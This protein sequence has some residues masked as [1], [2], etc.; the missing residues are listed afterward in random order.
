MM[1][2]RSG[3]VRN[4][5]TLLSGAA[6]AQLVN[7]GAFILIGRIYTPE[8]FGIF[9]ILTVSI[10]VLSVIVNGRYEL[11]ILLPKD[12][13]TAQSLFW[14]CI[15]ISIAVSLLAGI[16]ILFFLMFFRGSFSEVLIHHI[17]FIPVITFLLGIYQP[18]VNYLNRVRKYKHISISRILQALVFGGMSI[19]LG[20]LGYHNYG[21]LYGFISGHIAAVLYLTFALVK[22][23]YP[24]RMVSW[25]SQL[26]AAREY[27]SFPKFS[28]LSKLIM[29]FSLYQLPV[30]ALTY[31]FDAAVAGSFN[32]AFRLIIGPLMVV[33]GSYANVFYERASAVY[34]NRPGYFSAFARR[35]FVNL[36]LLA[37]VPTLIAGF[38]GKE[39]VVWLLGNSW[40]TTGVYLQYLAIY[41]FAVFIN[42][43][44]VHILK[45]REKLRSELVF[46]IVMMIMRVV[47]LAI[48]IVLLNPDLSVL[49]FS[50]AGFLVIIAI[51]FYIKKMVNI[52]GEEIKK[53]RKN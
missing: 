50:I 14:V 26:E 32:M 30:Y 45:V 52:K 7:F 36:T 49:L 18:A 41:A 31:Y 44:L 38:F 15:S 11:S 37:V 16:F 19:Y 40:Q 47:G 22:L 27:I 3:Y 48:G 35:N 2:T 6:I 34:R 4:I 23:E 17:Y 10:L 1:I 21:L 28:I 39:L 24:R 46:N 20:S 33:S 8:Q 42:N 29:T 9:A 12:E 53:S 51:L 5:F 13:T 43:P 25:R